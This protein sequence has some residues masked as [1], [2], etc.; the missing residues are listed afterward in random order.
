M[1]RDKVYNPKQGKVQF[2]NRDLKG[3]N[4]Y[5]FCKKQKRPNSKI[6]F[7]LPH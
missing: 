2:Q 6:E 1:Y 4:F 7:G 5:I 3:I